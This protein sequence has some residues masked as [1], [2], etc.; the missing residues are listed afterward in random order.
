MRISEPL[1]ADYIKNSV[2]EQV[3]SKDRKAFV[4]SLTARLEGQIFLSDIDIEEKYGELLHILL[5]DV[6]YAD[7][8]E[9]INLHLLSALLRREYMNT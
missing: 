9:G 4:D 7:E 2:N 6:E 3:D 1:L 8:T 5:H